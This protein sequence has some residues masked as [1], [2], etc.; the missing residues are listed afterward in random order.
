MP[1][2]P[3]QTAIRTILGDAWTRAGADARIVY[4][5]EWLGW[6]P[7]GQYHGVDVEHAGGREHVSR[8][9]P[10]DWALEDLLALERAG[11]LR[12]L[13]EAHEPADDMHRIVYEMTEGG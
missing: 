1:L 7:Y 12:R 3:E 6:L 5:T 13:S 10:A 2:T 8:R 11:I 4:Q 9:F